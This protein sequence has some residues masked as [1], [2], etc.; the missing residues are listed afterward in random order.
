MFQKVSQ[1]VKERFNYDIQSKS[2]FKNENDK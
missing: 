1:F 2:E